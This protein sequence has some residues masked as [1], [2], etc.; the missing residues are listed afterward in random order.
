[1]EIYGLQIKGTSKLI[2]IFLM[3]KSIIVPRMA[4]KIGLNLMYCW[5]CPY[6]KLPTTRH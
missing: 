3:N 6:M 1:M 5:N 4:I 2:P